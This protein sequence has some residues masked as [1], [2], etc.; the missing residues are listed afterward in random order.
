MNVQLIGLPSDATLELRVRK[1]LK[2]FEQQQ[3]IAF[4]EIEDKDQDLR[5]ALNND[6]SRHFFYL[7]IPGM[8]TARGRQRL[9]FYCEIQEG[10]T[11]FDLQF[12]RVLA[13]H[14]LNEKE[15]LNWKNC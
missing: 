6:P 15:K 12:G 5:S 1:L 13:C 14:L 7:E 11:K 8:K 3:R 10:T 4:K 9:R 2:T